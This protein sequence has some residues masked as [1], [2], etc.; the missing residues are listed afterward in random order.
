ML[1]PQNK[2]YNHQELTE[3][4]KSLEMKFPNLIKVQCVGKSLEKREVWAV[5]ITDSICGSHDSKPALF[6]DACVHA[7]EVSGT[8]T[9]LYLMDYLL[10]NYECNKEI[11]RLLKKRT[12]YIIPRI[13]PDG[14]E[15]FVM[16]SF[17]S[18]GNL[19]PFPEKENWT[20]LERC[21]VDNDGIQLLMRIKDKNGEWKISSKDERLMIP[22]KPY[23]YDGEYFRIYPEG[24]LV[25]QNVKWDDFKVLP[26][27][28][29]LNMNRNYADGWNIKTSIEEGGQYPFSEPEVFAVANFMMNHP[30]IGIGNDF[31]T[32]GGVLL[33]PYSHQTDKHF[34]QEDL[35]LYNALGAVGKEIT[36]Y[37]LVSA[38]EGFSLGISEPRRGC[39]DDWAYECLGILMISSELWNMGEMAGV[40]R[41]EGNYYPYQIKS[42]D[43]EITMLEWNDKELDGEGFIRW[44]KFKHAQLG[45]VEIGGWNWKY[46]SKNP[47]IKF[48][49]EECR[50]NALHCV[51]QANLLP[52]IEVKSYKVECLGEGLYN[53]SLTLENAGFLPTYITCKGKAN[54]LAKEV[55]V[56][57]K[58]DTDFTLINCEK[59]QK[60]GHIPGRFRRESNFYFGDATEGIPRKTNTVTWTLKTNKSDAKLM[61]N[62]NSQKG[63]RF[64]YEISLV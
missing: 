4:L 47:P 32:Y 59:S 46:T 36:G 8:Q 58:N 29:Q 18:W 14:A 6:V 56:V 31:H 13:N 52:E 7:G 16:T 11:N 64:D 60:L 38:F 21:D 55:E 39:I 41:E 3:I 25:G 30:N 63:G 9:C 54:K 19:N 15:K 10:S 34:P 26:K 17:E 61:L 44:K 20:G 1:I 23:E 48:L 51:K 5:T 12:I 40:H 62:I 37:D 35:D 28:F 42:E 50:K 53:V 57:L 49:E 45:E 22:R 27:E 2:Y 43:D 24:I 33:R